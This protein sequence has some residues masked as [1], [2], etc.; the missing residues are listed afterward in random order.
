[1]KTRTITG[2]IMAIV[3]IPILIWGDHLEIFNVF[4]LLLAMGAAWEFRKMFRIAKTLPL[5]LDI[6]TIVLTGL[7]CFTIIYGQKLGI[8]TL[9][10]P[11]MILIFI[12]V[13]IILVFLTQ[14]DGADFGSI[15]TTIIYSSFGFSAL[16]LLRMNGLKYVVF[17]LLAAMITDLFAYLLGMKY[18]KHKLIPIVS[19]KKSVE[20]AIAGLVFGTL[21]AS[22]YG[23]FGGV[24]AADFP[25]YWI[26]LI[27]LVLSCLSQVGDLLA[28]K[29]KRT[30]G[31]KD[32]SHLFPGHG[33]IM[34]RFD[35]TI[36]TAMIFFVILS[37]IGV[38]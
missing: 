2:F 6:L 33:G 9:I 35:S 12:V 4:C 16:A 23:I 31:I 32:Y 7:L 11:I 22:L 34:D 18:G 25:I 1:M 24:F 19:P 38:I 10:L 13:G 37:F 36:F 15:L 30:Y 17:I 21:A 27:A 14:F 28:S 20:G 26:I 3:M 8:Q 5:W 29:F